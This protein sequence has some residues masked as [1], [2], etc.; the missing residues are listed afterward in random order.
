[1]SRC[2]LG[3]VGGF[4]EVREVWIKSVWLVEG[5]VV[6]VCVHMWCL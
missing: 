4:I 6:C 3:G 5:E 1:M 2:G